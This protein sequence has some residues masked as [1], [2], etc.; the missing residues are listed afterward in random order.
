MTRKPPPK[1]AEG[2]VDLDG[3]GF[4]LDTVVPA[5]YSESSAPDVP[6]K[7]L[8]LRILSDGIQ[9]FK[10]GINCEWIRSKDTSYLTSFE[11]IC[12]V[13]N[14]DADGIRSRLERA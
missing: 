1:M 4:E 12:S 8:L 13:L 14:I 10:D 9:D 3:E 2:W 6:E 7:R 11:S 5:Q